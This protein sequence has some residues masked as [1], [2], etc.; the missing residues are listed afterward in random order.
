MTTNFTF[1]NAHLNWNGIEEFHGWIPGLYCGY[2]FEVKNR[3]GRIDFMSCSFYAG[4]PEDYAADEFTTW[5]L[6][7]SG[8][9]L[10]GRVLFRGYYEE[11]WDTE[12]GD[13]YM[14]V[15]RP[16]GDYEPLPGD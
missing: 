15:D 3:E 13:C 5:Y 9:T 10:T 16:F 4:T 14:K 2:N 6:E 12:C 11:D 1:L 8:L 7:N